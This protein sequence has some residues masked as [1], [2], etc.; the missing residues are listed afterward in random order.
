ML[1][2]TLQPSGMLKN[3]ALWQRVSAILSTL[4]L[5]LCTH[6]AQAAWVEARGEAVIENSRFDI[7]RQNARE[8]ALRQAAMQVGVRVYGH[9]S[10]RDGDLAR[11]DLDIKSHAYVREVKVIDEQVKGNVLFLT[12]N[13]NVE[14]LTQCDSGA[15][16]DYRKNLAVLGFSVQNAMDVQH[17]QLGDVDRALPA[18][19]AKQ[20]N[21]MGNALVM[22]NSHVRLYDDVMNAPTSSTQQRTL[23]NAAMVAKDMGVQF[24]LSGVIRDMSVTDPDSMNNSVAASFK[25][26]WG[27]LTG[28]GDYD[29]SRTFALEVFLHDGFNGSIVFQ[30]F[31]RIRAPW[32]EARNAALGFATEAFWQTD[33]GDQVGELLDN[34]AHELSDRLRCQPFMTRISK[35]NG[36]VL[37]FGSGAAAGIRP[38]DKLSVYRTFQ[39]QDAA[40]TQQLELTD[41][42]TA[43]TVSQVQPHFSRGELTIEAGRLNIQEDD[44]LIAW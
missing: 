11:D 25:R 1:M 43:L 9:Q 38:G 35:V 33:Y 15:A 16:N 14:Q 24:V 4:L 13:A 3:T 18:Y 8:D 17:G 28:W 39:F 22:E 2:L 6:S 32:R 29:Y 19:L 23:T 20:L 30:K 40:Q 5:V 41:L 44:L 31:Y 26:G 27:G 37:H 10:L 12:I 42:R 21:F 34:V 36:K 7:A